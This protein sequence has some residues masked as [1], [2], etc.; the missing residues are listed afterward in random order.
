MLP[1]LVSPLTQKEE[2]MSELSCLREILS[3][4]TWKF[5]IT[6]EFQRHTKAQRQ[7]SLDEM[8]AQLKKYIASRLQPALVSKIL[9]LLL[10]RKL[11]VIA[12][13]NFAPGCGPYLS[14]KQYGL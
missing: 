6:R 10:Y 14:P 1:S 8:H 5:K 9:L 3:K 7:K 4:L 12:I 11:T 2:I 13:Y